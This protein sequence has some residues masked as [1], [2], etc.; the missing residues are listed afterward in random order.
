[1]S[2]D[3]TGELLGSSLTRTLYLDEDMPQG[4]VRALV[5]LGYAATYA[6]W[7]LP[8]S[9]SDDDHLRYTAGHRY[10]LITRN[11]RDFELLHHAWRSWSKVWEVQ[12][13]P[14]HSGILVTPGDWDAETIAAEV[15]RFLRS[16]PMLTNALYS[17]TSSRGWGRRSDPP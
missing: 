7:V 12:P 14:E 4:A 6:R 13:A 2:G 5:R 15:D 10:I 8:P 9:T 16:G 1:M 3:A 17:W 11:R